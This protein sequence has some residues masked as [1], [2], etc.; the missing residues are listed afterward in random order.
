MQ[1]AEPTTFWEILK[2]HL[3]QPEYIHVLINPLPIYGLGLGVFA[4]ILAL[5]LRSR[6]AQIVALALVFV[7]AA[8]AWPVAEFGEAAYD[9]IEAK[10][11]DDGALWLDA[12][13]QRATRSLPAFYALAVVALLALVLPWK[14]P[15]SATPLVIATLLLTFVCFALAGWIAYAGG[16]VRHKEFRYSTPP[17]K[18]G[19]YEEMRD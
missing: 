13:A 1:S 16:P 7:S 4:L 3:N 11:D 18:A 15:K 12:H 10:S 6:A 19:G 5:C 8:S 14:F 2:G 9:R 17:E